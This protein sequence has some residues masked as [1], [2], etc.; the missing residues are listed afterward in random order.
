MEKSIK[1]KQVKSRL[2]ILMVFSVIALIIMGLSLKASSDKTSTRSKAYIP[3]EVNKPITVKGIVMQVD[4]CVNGFCYRILE[5][6]TQKSYYLKESPQMIALASQKLLKLMSSP[7]GENE[8]TTVSNI[9][10]RYIDL[11][12]Y[13]T[14]T[15]VIQPVEHI[16][17]DKVALYQLSACQPRPNCLSAEK[18]CKLAEPLGGWCAVSASKVCTDIGLKSM[19]PAYPCDNNL[20]FHKGNYICNDDFTGTID[21]QDGKLCFSADQ[22]NKLGKDKCE[23]YSS[24]KLTPT[25]AISKDKFS[26]LSN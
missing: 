2:I 23:K 18:P 19:T 4:P 8:S 13:V 1:T 21:S 17:V 25:P 11:Q 7:S 6:K 3:L 10:K 12:T 16:L 5:N 20:G 22:L 15:L 14:G 9:F 26:T 24:C